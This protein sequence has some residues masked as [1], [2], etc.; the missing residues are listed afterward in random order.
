[1]FAS[2][3]V[4]PAAAGRQPE[5]VLDGLIERSSTGRRKVLERPGAQ[6]E[7]TSRSVFDRDLD[8]RSAA[9]PTSW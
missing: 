3:A 8:R 1:M 6:I 7:A 5:A 2:R 4:K 9:T